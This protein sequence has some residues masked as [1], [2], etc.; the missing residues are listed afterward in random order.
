MRSLG[1]QPDPARDDAFSAFDGSGTDDLVTGWIECWF[2]LSLELLSNGA[3]ACG[4]R[5]MPARVRFD[6]TRNA[7]G[8]GSS[9]MYNARLTG[10]HAW[11][12]KCN[13][14][15]AG[16]VANELRPHP[17]ETDQVGAPPRVVD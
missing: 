8:A 3:G 1:V 14:N 2:L 13:R 6:G 5:Y 9:A 15:E 16:T 12:S 10:A 7:R 4:Y 17:G 11:T